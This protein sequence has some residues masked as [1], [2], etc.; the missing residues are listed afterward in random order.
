MI[1]KDVVYTS[2]VEVLDI[3]VGY[4]NPIFFFL[5]NFAVMVKR[6]LIVV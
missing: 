4:L 6:N 2:S 3:V 5:P 1:L